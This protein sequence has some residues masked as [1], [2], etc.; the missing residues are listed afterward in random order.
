[1][2]IAL[3]VMSDKIE[4]AASLKASESE[5]QA[6]IKPFNLQQTP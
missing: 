4:G 5:M 2:H 6:L 1:M 3:S